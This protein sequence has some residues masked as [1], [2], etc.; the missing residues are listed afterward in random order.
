V[1]LDPKK[2]TL[3]RQSQIK[4]HAELHVLLSMITPTPWLERNPTYKEQQDEIKDKDLHTYGFLGYP[5]L[6]TADII[7]YKAGKVPVGIDQAP[8]VEL[9]REITRRFNNFYGQV[10]PE[11]QTILTP[12]PKVLGTDGRKMSKSYNNAVLLT[13]EPAVVEKK[14]LSMVTDTARMRRTDAGNP[15]VCPFY[16][17][18]HALYSDEAAKDEVRRGCT[19]AGIGCTDCKRYVIPKVLAELEPIRARRAEFAKDG[20]AVESILR[21]G[22]R[23]AHEVANATMHEVRKAMGLE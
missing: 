9:S 13:D 19:T 14:L 10:F 7:I 20:T 23:A 11:P 1:G 17:T 4:E 15:D 12:I 2:S 16:V 3:F 22:A 21:D 6:Q 8:H 18:Y 5:V